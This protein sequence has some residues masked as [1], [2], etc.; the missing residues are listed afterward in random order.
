MAVQIPP[1]EFEPFAFGGV[2]AAVK[3]AAAKSG[4]LWVVPIDEIN[5]AQDFNIRVL[6]DD[7]DKGINALADL[8]E[9]HG[10]L[11]TKPLSVVIDANN[12]WFVRDGHRRLE[13]ARRVNERVEAGTASCPKIE[14]LPCLLKAGG[15]QFEDL[16]YDLVIENTGEPLTPLEIGIAIARLM[17]YGQEPKDIAKR[18][19]ITTK[20]LGDLISLVESPPAVRNMV[21][22][23]R[24]AAKT[25]IEAIAQHGADA[26]KV[27]RGAV[28]HAEAS[29][30]TRATPRN[31]RAVAP[32]TTR[33]RA[34][35]APV[36][37]EVR[38]PDR[39]K[40][41]TESTMERY[42][43]KDT[44]LVQ[45]VWDM[46]AGSEVTLDAIR[47]IS[48]T[49]QADWWELKEGEEGQVVI[50]TNIMIVVYR[51]I[52]DEEAAATGTR[53]KPTAATQKKKATAK[54]AGK[55]TGGRKK[56]AALPIEPVDVSDK[57]EDEEV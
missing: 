34:A 57:P 50:K 7:Y 4:D 29:G 46:K 6:N 14:A 33:K 32:K 3:D 24:V 25:A 1:A 51:P 22:T 42:V 26:A 17:K 28:D 37:E 55:K 16:I 44:R 45:L 8:I 19:G 30:K 18:L 15:T 10:F 54:G 43:N 21:A 23:N 47:P 20:Y 2:R 56:A 12:D 27:L 49:F 48:R 53:K 36:G 5:V 13:A 9:Q 52:T 11:R 39:M 38:P 41:G 40:S 35:D 31:V